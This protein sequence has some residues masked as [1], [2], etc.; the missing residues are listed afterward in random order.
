MIQQLGSYSH[1]CLINAMYL[2]CHSVFSKTKC[3][4]ASPVI[5]VKFQKHSKKKFHKI[6]ALMAAFLVCLDSCSSS[7]LL[8]LLR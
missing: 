3:F 1:S 2:K 4:T 8:L 7:S 6:V 5:I